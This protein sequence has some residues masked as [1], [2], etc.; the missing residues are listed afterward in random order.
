MG[1]A[2]EGAI[3]SALGFG[4]TKAATSLAYM[5]AMGSVTSSIGF[6][7]ELDF[8]IAMN[9]AAFATGFHNRMACS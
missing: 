3:L 9:L 4:L 2:Q 5:T 7:S 6:V 1:I 8:M